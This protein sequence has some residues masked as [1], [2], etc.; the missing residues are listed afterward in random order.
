MGSMYVYTYIFEDLTKGE[1]IYTYIF[2]YS[3]TH[4]YAPQPPPTHTCIQVI[5]AS[6]IFWFFFSFFFLMYLYERVW[7]GDMC[8]SSFFSWEKFRTDRENTW[9]RKKGEFERKTQTEE[10]ERGVLPHFWQPERQLFG[11]AAAPH[12]VDCMSACLYIYM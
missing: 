3:Y 6:H 8:P 12:P 9:K 7:P 2:L 5:C 4:T 11:F 10:K 1:Y